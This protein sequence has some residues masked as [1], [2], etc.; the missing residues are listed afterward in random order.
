MKQIFG[1]ILI[2]GALVVGYDAFKEWQAVEKLGALAGLSEALGG[3][4]KQ[5]AVVKGVIS[6]VALVIGLAFMDDSSA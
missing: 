3:P 1:A 6:L 4:S 5:D 2:I